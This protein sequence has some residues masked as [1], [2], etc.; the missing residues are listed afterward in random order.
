MDREADHDSPSPPERT[1]RPSEAHAELALREAAVLMAP[2]ARWLLRHGVPYP[3]FADMLKAVFVAAALD[4]LES[5]G[6]KATHS[7]LSVLSGVHRKDVRAL[8]SGDPEA[9]PPRSVPLASA[10]FTRW[11]TDPKYRAN[12]KPRPLPRTGTPVSFETL[13]RESS[14]DVHPRTVLDE[15]VRSGL[16]RVDGDEVVPLAT[17]FVPSR[18]L[19]ELTALFSANV[20]D[21]IAAAVH[22]LTLKAPKY[23]EQSVFADGL[24]PASIDSLHQ[25]ARDIWG[26]AFTRMV[27]EARQRVDADVDADADVR[28]RFGVYFYAEP[29]DAK[30]AVAAPAPTSRAKRGSRRAS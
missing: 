15:L 4:E 20:S 25:S 19:D 24:T 11:I 1:V 2:L 10:V 13:A 18:K 27:A 5:S 9:V 12:G 23:L 8:Q 7:A 26:A 3:A 22:N 29:V 17:S 30:P 21:H 6:A 16:A 14:N 28:M